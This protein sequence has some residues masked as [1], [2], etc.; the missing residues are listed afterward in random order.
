VPSGS[1][2]PGFTFRRKGFPDLPSSLAAFPPRGSVAPLTGGACGP[3]LVASMGFASGMAIERGP[4]GG[5][6]ARKGRQA[7]HRGGARRAS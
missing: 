6:P 5:S 1:R 3:S 7:R 2:L 4:L